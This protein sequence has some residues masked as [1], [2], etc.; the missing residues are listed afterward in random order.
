MEL[1][2]QKLW[3]TPSSQ[4][5][6]EQRIKKIADASGNPAAVWTAVMLF[7]NYVASLDK[8]EV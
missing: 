8:A 6:M 2:E 3:A 7:N 4:E 5:D 1:K